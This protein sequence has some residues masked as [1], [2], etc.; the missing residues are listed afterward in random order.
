MEKKHAFKPNSIVLS[1]Y[2]II[3]NIGCGAFGKLFSAEDTLSHDFVAIKVESTKT[4]YPQLE[5]EYRTYQKFADTPNF[6]RVFFYGTEGDHR[7]LVMDLLGK[8]LE[9]LFVRNRAPLSLKTVLML[10]DQMLIGIEYVH[11]K[12]IIH[13]DIKP[14]N[15]VMGVGNRSNDCFI[16][17]FGLSKEYRSPVTHAH[18]AFS[19]G[20]SFTGTARYASIN[21]M[22]GYEQSR[23]DDMESLGYVWMYL[24]RGSLPWQGLPANTMQQKQDKI[25]EVKMRTPLEILCAG[26]PCEFV[27]YLSDVRKLGFNEEPNYSNYRQMFRNLFLRHCFPY[28]YEYDWCSQV[29]AKPTMPRQPRTQPATPRRSIRRNMH[30]SDPLPNLVSTPKVEHVSRPKKRVVVKTPDEQLVHNERNRFSPRNIQK[31]NG[32]PK[33]PKNIASIMLRRNSIGIWNERI[34]A[35]Q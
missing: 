7:F 10:I 15:F 20:K 8:S 30:P 12:S 4:K 34:I 24:L 26:F 3:E 19:D 32:T 28:D 25:L 29:K 31:P 33:M 23:R 6:P 22:R 35:G 21:A 16:I 13:R 1:H 2:R 5:H 9:D 27:Q 11:K 17:D 14:D 18:K